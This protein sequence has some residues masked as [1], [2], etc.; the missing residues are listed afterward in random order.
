MGSTPGVNLNPVKGW[1]LGSRRKQHSNK[2]RSWE[3]ERG[4][5]KTFK[6]WIMGGG[7]GI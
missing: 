1:I 2:G 4:R 6:G 3:E 7:N 5:R